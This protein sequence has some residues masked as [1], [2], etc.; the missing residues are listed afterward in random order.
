M[1]DS[2]KEWFKDE[3]TVY[4]VLERIFQLNTLVGI[5]VGGSTLGLWGYYPEKFNVIA[6]GMIGVYSIYQIIYNKRKA[7]RKEAEKL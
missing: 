5:F 1:F 6:G 4:A 3:A 7:I 2:I